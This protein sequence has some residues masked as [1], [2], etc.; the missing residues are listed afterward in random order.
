MAASPGRTLVWRQSAAMGVAM[1]AI[2]RFTC[3]PPVAFLPCLARGPGGRQRQCLGHAHQF[4]QRP[5]THFPHDVA[6]MDLHRDL[7]Y[8]KLVS[9]LLVHHAL[10][11]VLQDL[12]LAS[13]ESIVPGAEV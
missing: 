13:G 2:H 1:E 12:L 9:Y 11:D 10:R 5:R 6:T 8:A 3:Y 7:R 4:R